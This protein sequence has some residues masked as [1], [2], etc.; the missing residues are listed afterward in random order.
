MCLLPLNGR[1]LP[2][3][4]LRQSIND[5]GAP[6]SLS[7]PLKN[8]AADVPVEGDQFPIDGEHRL[9]LS[10]SDALFQTTEKFFVAFWQR[11]MS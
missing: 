11:R 4:V 8:V 5:P 3:Q 2:V 9:H 10:L 7:L 6:T 1:E